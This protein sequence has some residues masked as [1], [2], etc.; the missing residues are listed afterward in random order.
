MKMI[1]HYL[2]LH[3]DRFLVY[4]SIFQIVLVLIPL[5]DI[6]QLN[7]FNIIV[8]ISYYLI[9]LLSITLIA[10]H[11]ILKLLDFARRCVILI[12]LLIIILKLKD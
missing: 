4:V 6:Y 1:N 3:I 2:I 10:F 11:N 12:K 5:V 7:V 9:I 8:N